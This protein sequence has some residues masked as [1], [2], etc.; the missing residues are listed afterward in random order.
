MNRMLLLVSAISI[1]LIGLVSGGTAA[2]IPV[3]I[4][5]EFPIAGNFP[6]SN[7]VKLSTTEYALALQLGGGVNDLGALSSYDFATGIATELYSFEQ[8]QFGCHP[9]NGLT[10]IGNSLYGAAQGGGNGMGVLYRYDLATKA[11]EVVHELDVDTTGISIASAT[12]LADG[13][14][15]GTV[16]QSSRLSIYRLN[17]ST[18]ALSSLAMPGSAVNCSYVP[19]SLVQLADGYVYG[20]CATNL[21][22]GTAGVVKIDVS[23]PNQVSFVS[24]LDSTIPNSLRP[25]AFLHAT[26][27]KFYGKLIHVKQHRSFNR[28][29]TANFSRLHIYYS[30]SL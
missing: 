10:K 12:G 23:N 18:N 21:N 22:T 15:I 17:P 20:A 27:G 30:F 7:P 26:D 5:T 6:V 14:L 13:S 4:V 19:S 2:G 25:R 3:E 8:C 16:E 11:Y 1:L 29:L 24:F 28:V 9:T